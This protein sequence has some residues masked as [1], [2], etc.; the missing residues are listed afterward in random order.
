MNKHLSSEH[1]DDLFDYIGVTKRRWKS[2]GDSCQICCPIHREQR[3]S[4]GVSL[5]LQIFHCFSCGEKGTIPY[6]LYKSL[7]DEFKTIYQAVKFIR[8]RYKV[9]ISRFS[10]DHITRIKRYE[11]FFNIE[12]KRRVVKPMHTLAPFKSGIETYRYFYDRGF[13]DEMLEMFMI[14]YDSIYK[15]VTIPVFWEDSTLA[16]IIGRFIYP[17]SQAERYKVYDFSRKE[18][19]FPI[20][21]VDL[22][23]G[24]I[25]LVEGVFDAIRLFQLGYRNTLA[26]QTT[27][28]SKP[29]EE[30]LLRNVNS[31]ILM[32]DNDER[33][34]IATQK[35]IDRLKGQLNLYTL[36]YPFHGKDPCDW[37]YDEIKNILKNRKPYYRRK[38]VRL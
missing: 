23:T 33:G 29:Q 2:N 10:N 35:I 4:C 16:G 30:Y 27:E 36:Y 11:D 25:I 32:L 38:V 8:D 5:S 20:D 26:L 37:S 21:K 22:S 24:E 9:E 31:I 13:D 28:L 17:R 12:Q 14:G 7:P 34:Q 19:L 6:L 18:L 3:P 15:T 1:I